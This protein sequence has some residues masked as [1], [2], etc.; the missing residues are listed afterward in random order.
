MKTLG[1]Y[2]LREIKQY[3][4]GIGD[5]SDCQIFQNKKCAFSQLPSCWN[6]DTPLCAPI[7]KDEVLAARV[8]R[9]C[10]NVEK[11]IRNPGGL[12]AETKD[13]SRIDLRWERFLSIKV[14]D[15]LEVHDL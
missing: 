5:C 13:G 1:D 12:F 2:T 9:E 8:L 7:T 6:I 15:T 10:A 11:I 4:N 14:G 3:C